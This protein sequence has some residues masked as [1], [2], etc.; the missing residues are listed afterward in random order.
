M[1]DLDRGALEAER[2]FLLRS[3]DDLEDEREAGNVDDGTYQT[4]RDDYT[5]RGRR[6]PIA[7]RRHRSHAARSAAVVEGRARGHRRRDHRV[8]A[9]R[10]VRV[11][12]RGGAAA[13][14]AR[15]SPGT[16]R[17]AAG[18]TTPDPGPALAGAVRDNP[19]SYAAHIAYARYLLQNRDFTDA[20]HEFG[21]AARLDPSQPEPPTYAGWAGALL[22]QQVTNSKTRET[23][24]S[25]ALE[26]INE[27]I[28]AHPKYP[29][30]Y[31]LKGVT[32][33]NFQG[34]AKHAIPAF[35]QFLVLTDDSNP[36][37]PQVLDVLAQAEKA[38][39][40]NRGSNHSNPRRSFVAKKPEPQ[41]DSNKMYRA[42]ITTDR[43]PI[44][45]D[46]DPQLAPNTVNNFVGLARDGYYDGLTFHRVVPDFVIQGGCPEGTGRGGPGYKFADEPVT[47]EYRLGA[48]A[49][50]NS[51]P[52]TN[53]SQF[54]ICIDDCQS[55]LA[56]SYN[57]FGYVVDGMDVALG[58]KVGDKM[59]KV[60]I[61]ERD[62]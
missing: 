29:D 35:Q 57:L 47:G 45:M 44:V 2:D 8:R 32:L 37:R 1:S 15:R 16:T 39:K 52:D 9:R 4:L 23:L 41:T 33:F 49:M 6:D 25:A 50:A 19:K 58:T 56:K 7:R 22:A 17:S 60:E 31:A 51:G 42:T 18:T 28:K 40:S 3:L 59:N 34:D 5:A 21:S 36:I 55:K 46:L 10:R 12:A 13:V 27:V 24:L 30:A 61:E 54:F 38:A 43:G 48:V 26:R 62:R 20:I 53:G 11:D 14:R